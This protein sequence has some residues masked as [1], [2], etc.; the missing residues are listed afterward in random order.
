MNGTSLISGGTSRSIRDRPGTR[1]A[2]GDFNG[3]GKADIL[4][5]N[6]DGTAGGVADG[7][8]QH[9][10]P[11][12]MSAPIRAPAWHVDGTRRLQRRRQGRHPVAERQRHRRGLAD[13]RHDVLSTGAN[14]G[15]NPGAAWHAMRRGDFN[16]D[17]KADILWQNDD[18]TPAVW[19]MDG[20]SICQRRQCRLQSGRGLARSRHRRLQRR[21]QGRHP[22]AERRR[23]AGGVADERHRCYFIRTPATRSGHIVAPHVNMLRTA[24]GRYATVEQTRSVAWHIRP[25]AAIDPCVPWHTLETKESRWLKRPYSPSRKLN[26]NTLTGLKSK[27]RLPNFVQRIQ[28]DGQTLRLEFCISRLEDQQPSAAP[29]GKRYPACRLVLSVGAGVDLINKMQQITANLIKAGV[30]KQNSPSGA[31][32][33]LISDASQDTDNRRARQRTRHYLSA[34]VRRAAFRIRY[35]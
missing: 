29:V 8:P 18:G 7:W 24:L 4:W 21:R 5:Q 30:L 35:G 16:G 34:K 15:V 22:V 14:V 17:G 1:S 9:A 12:P 20:T 28:F 13:G 31:K 27:K 6:D 23:H 19:L 2:A 3:D 25:A 33:E 11:A 26:T 32:V 10:R